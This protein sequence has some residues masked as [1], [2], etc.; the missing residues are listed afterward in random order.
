MKGEIANGSEICG[1]LDTLVFTCWSDHWTFTLR[2][3]TWHYINYIIKIFSRLPWCFTENS[4]ST[5]GY[6]C[7]LLHAGG[8]SNLVDDPTVYQTRQIA[9]AERI[10]YSH[11]TTTLL[12]YIRRV[13]TSRG[14][15]TWCTKSTKVLSPLLCLLWSTIIPNLF[16]HPLILVNVHNTTCTFFIVFEV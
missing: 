11:L 4:P 3:R 2:K 12:I 7:R 14:I 9:A 5:I 1:L 8:H 13:E 10:I 15:R 16:S 6:L